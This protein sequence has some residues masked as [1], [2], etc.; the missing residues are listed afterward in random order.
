[1]PITKFNGPDRADDDINKN[2]V[3][4]TMVNEAH[5]TKIKQERR[6]EAID[7]ILEYRKSAPIISDDEIYRIRQE[8]RDSVFID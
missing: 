5:K 7:A 2:D 6:A 8:I 1:M 3:L 4:N